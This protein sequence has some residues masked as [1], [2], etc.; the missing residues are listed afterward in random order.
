MA[1]PNVETVNTA[2]G[3]WLLALA[4]LL[5]VAGVIG[6]Y[7]LA[8][9]PSYVRAASLI[10]GLVLGAGVA[11]VSAPGQSFIEFARESYRE[12]RKVVWP[13][14]KEAGQMTGLVFAFVVIMALFLWSADKLIEWVI[15]SLVLGWK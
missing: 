4:F 8:Q 5:L 2:S 3:K 1:N 13:T 14:R 9:Q 15:F 12:V 7:L 11:L 10:G 6:F